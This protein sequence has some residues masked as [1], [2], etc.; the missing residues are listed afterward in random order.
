MGTISGIPDSMDTFCF[1]IEVEDDAGETDKQESC[2][3]I[4]E[5]TGMKGDANDDGVINILDV[6]IGVNIILGV[7]I[8]TPE[9]ACAVDCNGPSGNCDGDGSVN[10]LDAIKIVNLILELDECP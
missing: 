10:V 2:M 1:I 9:E 8:P 7:H 6:V 5:Y 4:I 3:T